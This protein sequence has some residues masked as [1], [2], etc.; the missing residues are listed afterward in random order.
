[1]TAGEYLV[2][3]STLAVAE[4]GV[5][6]LNINTG[7]GVDVLVPFTSITCDLAMMDLSGDLETSTHIADLTTSTLDAIL[8]TSV[9]SADLLDQNYNGDLT[10]P[11]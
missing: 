11:N 10:C 2:D 5:H 9:Y 3:Y 6:F 1:M 4:A 7:T 8:T